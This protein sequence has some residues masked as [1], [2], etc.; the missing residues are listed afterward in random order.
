VNVF[1]LLEGEE[2]II[3][4][5]KNK[6]KPLVVHYAETF[7]IPASVGEYTIRPYGKSEGGECVTIKASVR[8]NA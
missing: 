1:N 5:P 7:I 4:S 6:F 3:E 2:V 8:F